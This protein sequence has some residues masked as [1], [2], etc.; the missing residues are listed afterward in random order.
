MIL[1]GFSRFYCRAK[2]AAE[3][4]SRISPRAVESLQ[5]ACSSAKSSS[6]TSKRAAFEAPAPRYERNYI[7][8]SYVP[9]PHASSLRWATD[10]VSS[11]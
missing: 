11:R 6:P 4:H 3:M 2:E 5:R 7:P 10:N 8:V 9:P 1:C